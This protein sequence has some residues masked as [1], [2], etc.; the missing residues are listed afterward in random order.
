MSVA[1]LNFAPSSSPVAS[2]AEFSFSDG[3]GSLS[4]PAPDAPKLPPVRVD[5]DLPSFASVKSGLPVADSFETSPVF[6]DLPPLTAPSGMEMQQLAQAT[7]A[8]PISEDA[9]AFG[10]LWGSRSADGG[11]TNPD[12]ASASAMLKLSEY[13]DN[14]GN[15]DS[16]IFVLEKRQEFPLETLYYVSVPMSSDDIAYYRDVYAIN[17]YS[18]DGKYSIYDIIMNESGN[19]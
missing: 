4:S 3:L 12:H 2:D 11:F 1:S 18:F 9:G 5:P 14:T 6:S 19:E 7:D 10:I 15:M 16:G 17:D 8:P 13:V